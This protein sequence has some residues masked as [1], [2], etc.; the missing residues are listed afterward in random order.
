MLNQHDILVI[1]KQLKCVVLDW[2]P[3]SGGDICNSYLLRTQNY[4]I[5][6]KTH[7]SKTLL[8]AEYLGLQAIAKTQTIQTPQVIHF[9]DLKHLSYLA[10][11]WIETKAATTN[12]YIL[13]GQQLAHL[14][15]SSQDQFGGTTSNFIGHLSQSNSYQ[16]HWNDFYINQRLAPQLQLAQSKHLLENKD[17]PSVTTLKE[18][19]AP[20][21]E[22]ITPSLLHGDLWNGNVFISKNDIPYIFDPATYYGHSEVDIAMTKLFGGFDTV[23]YDTYHNIIPKDAYTD[24]RIEL[25]QLYYLLVHLNMFGSSYYTSVYGILK[26]YF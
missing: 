6:L 20:Y 19:C 23:F 25:Y 17:I 18:T 24:S 13:L 22:N 12:N 15:Q 2:Q 1:S 7:S 14:H 16:D 5:F 4:N 21:F 10:L 3:I 9:G 8:N 26:K 11:E